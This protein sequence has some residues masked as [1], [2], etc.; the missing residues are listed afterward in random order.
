MKKLTILFTLTV[1]LLATSPV[2]GQGRYGA[3][4]AECIKYL[5]FYLE[6]M[7]QG[8]LQEAEPLW[9][10]AISLCP[11]TAN[12]NMLLDGMKIIRRNINIYKNNPIRKKSLIDSLMML[13]QMRIDNYPKYIIP[14]KTNQAMDM[15]KYSP[16]GNEQAVFTVLGEA[17]DVAKGKTAIA[18]PVRYMDYAN[19]MYKAGTMSPEDVMTAYQKAMATAELIE[20]AKPSEEIANAKKD[21]ENLLMLSGVASCDNLVA[22][23]T[24]R[25]EASPNDKDI[26]ANIV[27]MLSAS[28]CLDADLFLN[29]VESLHKIEATHSSA[30]LLYKLYSQRDNSEQASVYMNEAITMLGDTDPKQKADYYFEYSTFC[31]KKAGKP[32]E[33]VK[34]AKSAAEAN[35]ELSGKAYFL[36]ATI[37]GAQKCEGNDIEVRAPYWVAVDYLVKAKNADPALAEEVN[38]LISS[39]SKYFPQQSEAFMFD[40]LDGSSYTVSCGGMHETTKVRTQK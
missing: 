37:W 13:H 29:A 5:S 8:N 27:S 33:A 28:Q 1:A 9:Q 12:Q 24:P 21:I 6:Y 14:A 36:I 3:D 20:K 25:Y 11:P 34:A 40:V 39:Y 31:F 10:K 30:Y 16:K 32:A 4:S 35:P 7:K 2:S 22:L 38:P 19:E 26:L 18:I 17:M 15:M 23:F